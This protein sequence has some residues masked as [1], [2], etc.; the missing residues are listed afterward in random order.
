M[1][2]FPDWLDPIM[3]WF[4]LPALGWLGVL[5]NRQAKHAT[6]I[7]VL[8]AKSAGQEK[9]FERIMNKLDGIEKALRKD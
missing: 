4:I 9:Q 5:H 2:A 3:R 8:Q 6:D 7:A 1:T